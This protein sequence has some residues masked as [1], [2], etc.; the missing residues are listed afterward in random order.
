M[1]FTQKSTKQ[2]LQMLQAPPLL[3]KGTL[4][5]A[6]LASKIDNSKQRVHSIFFP[7]EGKILL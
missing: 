4:T 7:G 6:Y 3:G 2:T 5:L 1:I